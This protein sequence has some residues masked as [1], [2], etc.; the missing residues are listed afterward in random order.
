MGK[1]IVLYGLPAAGKTTQADL[2]FKKYGL[3]QFGMGDKLR[4]EI[5]SGTELG[6]K[7][8][9]TVTNG[10]LVSDDLIIQVLHNVQEQAKTTGI[11]FDGFPRMAPQAKLLDEMLEEIGLTVD[12]FI[13]LAITPSEAEKRIDPD[14]ADDR[15]RTSGGCDRKEKRKRRLSVQFDGVSGKGM[16]EKRSGSVCVSL[17]FLNSFLRAHSKNALSICLHEIS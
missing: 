17:L 9:E 16:Q 2:L 3:Y 10:R 7:I 11:V 8:Q 15:R 13:L 5:N 12:R 14:S 6:K 4:A 1:I